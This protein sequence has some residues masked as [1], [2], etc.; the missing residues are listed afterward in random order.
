M[1]LAWRT[2]VLGVVFFALLGLLSLRMWQLQV[3]EGEEYA[4]R[5]E[6]NQV[7][8]APTPAPRGEIRDANGVLLAGTRPALA[9][10]VDAKILNEEDEPELVAQLSALLGLPVA[11]VEEFIDDVQY[12]GDRV[13]IASELT[14]AQALFITEHGENFPGV[15][16]EPQPIRTYPLGDVA[17]D[18]IGFIGLPQPADVEAGAE[19]T[20]LLGRAGLER[21]YDSQLQ[22]TSGQIVYRFDAR[23]QGDVLSQTV[24][25]PGN[26]LYLTIDVELQ[27]VVE[28]SLAEGLQLARELYDPENPECEPGLAEDGKDPRCPVRA[29]GVVL[30]AT[31]GAVRAMASVP[32]YDPNI[33]IGGVSQADL[34]ALPDG[35]FNNFAIQGEYAP[36]STFKAVTYFTAYEEGVPPISGSSLEA[37]ILCSGTLRAPFIGDQSRQVWNNWTGSDDGEQNVHRAL[38][39]SCNTYF[40]EIALRIWD[41]NKGTD[42]ED[43]LQD[44][45]RHFGFGEPTAIDLP[46]ER[47]GIVPDRALFEL[48]A[49]ES[50]QRLD[51]SRLELASPWLGGDLLQA[52]V[53]Q[54]AVTVTPLQLA[55]AYAAMV[56]G[57]FLYEP[58]IV[59]RIENLDGTTVADREPEVIRTI[60]VAASTVAGFRRD[61]QSVV[62]EPDGTAH[63]AF[64]DFGANVALVGGKT[65]TA[66]IIKADEDQPGVDTA[67][68]AGVAPINNPRYVVVVVVE[69]G[70]SG[71][72][73]A[74]PT[75]RPILQFLM[76]GAEAVTPI[77]AG[78]DAD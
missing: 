69:R 72:R 21:E 57:G 40:W 11:D 3:A 68:F 71:G 49:D 7:G 6:S 29:V 67:L 37:P 2:G 44:W 5:A 16:V 34:D 58:F 15:A 25:T 9:A 46:F 26:T 59:N 38:T 17:S 42:S 52:A 77:G 1:N 4:E 30:D 61:L 43:M 33:F 74:A 60:P 78:E 56:N 75:A 8:F 23:R 27:E 62:N 47:S 51:P 76:N 32:T 48:W 50:P 35:V 39:R 36:A 70:G 55:N 18:V 41:E 20:V 14:Q 13:P 53:G 54:G 65:G 45:A 28:R 22:G 64:A 66:E 73:I 24:P 31:N 10:V 19:P 63:P 12:R